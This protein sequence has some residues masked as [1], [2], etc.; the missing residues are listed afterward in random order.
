[1]SDSRPLCRHTADMPAIFLHQQTPPN[2]FFSF[3]ASVPPFE[4]PP[5]TRPA[6]RV[7]TY[8]DNVRPQRNAFD[9][10]TI[11]RTDQPFRIRDA[12]GVNITN[13]RFIDSG[14]GECSGSTGVVVTDNVGLN[15]ITRWTSVEC[16]M[17]SSQF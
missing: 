10:N 6:L 15:N 7:V 4:T 17:N 16:F 1:M 14:L 3:V 9:S 2:A 13:N 11:S 8:L 12:D 5:S